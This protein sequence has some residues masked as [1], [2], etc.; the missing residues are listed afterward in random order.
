MTL[1]SRFYCT[2]MRTVDLKT[3]I[4]MLPLAIVFFLKKK[5]KKK[6]NHNSRF[7]TVHF[8]VNKRITYPTHILIFST[9]EHENATSCWSTLPAERDEKVGSIQ[10]PLRIHTNA[11]PSVTKAAHDLLSNTCPIVHS[12]TPICVYTPVHGVAHLKIVPSSQ[13]LTPLRTLSTSYG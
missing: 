2:Y 1:Q 11:V 5:K 6:K 12:M 3:H 9:F 4:L 7:E 8:E 10:S 13:L